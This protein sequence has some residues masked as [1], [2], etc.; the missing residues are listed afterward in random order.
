MTGLFFRIKNR[1]QNK[2]SDE[3]PVTGAEILPEVGLLFT[4]LCV[5]CDIVTPTG[6]H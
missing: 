6:V 3:G 1:R 5:D 2:V 4:I